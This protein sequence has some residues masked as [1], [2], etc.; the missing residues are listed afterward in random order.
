MYVHQNNINM[1]Q[2][3]APIKPYC[4]V[5]HDAGKPG[6]DTHF[7]RE[8]PDPS[9]R[10]VCPTLLELVCGYCRNN[11]HT[12]KYCPVLKAKTKQEQS[13]PVR[14]PP[15]PTPKEG[16]PFRSNAFM[17]LDSDTEE[18]DAKV[19]ETKFP[20]FPGIPSAAKEPTKLNYAAAL[21]K[22]PEPAPASVYKPVPWATCVQ[23]SCITSWAD[24]CSS[25]ED[26]DC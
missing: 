26:E 23:Q 21:S 1:S 10:V 8:T 7:V 17:C 19:E 20:A 24:D 9:A 14:A 5:C 6:Y 12:V 3:N 16:K 11:G 25:D 2:R 15:K 13:K 4:K 22:A 18:E